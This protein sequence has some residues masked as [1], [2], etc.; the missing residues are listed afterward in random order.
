[1]CMRVKV[2]RYAKGHRHR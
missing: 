2:A 1:V